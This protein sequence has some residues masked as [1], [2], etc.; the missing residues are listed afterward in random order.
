MPGHLRADCALRHERLIRQQKPRDPRR[1]M[2]VPLGSPDS[3]KVGVTGFEPATSWSRNT[4]SN[5]PK[6]AKSHC[7]SKK[8][9]KSRNTTH[10]SIRRDSLPVFISWRRVWLPV[11]L[12][13]ASPIRW[14][15]LLLG[16]RTRSSRLQSRGLHRRTPPLQPI[17]ST[18]PA[19]RTYHTSPHAVQVACTQLSSTL[20][21]RQGVSRCPSWLAQVRQSRVALN[22]SPF[23]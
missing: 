17:V 15:A 12:P 10:A 9:F 22:S 5:K 18:S 7:F 2:C 6:L 16:R 11:F 23:A 8:Y 4:T 21:N 3:S 13:A 1:Q 14:R 20:R 19:R